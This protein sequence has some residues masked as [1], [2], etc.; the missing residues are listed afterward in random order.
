MVMSWVWVPVTVAVGLVVMQLVW[1]AS[2]S[3]RKIEYRR[4]VSWYLGWSELTASTS[5][6]SHGNYEHTA[7][8][9]IRSIR[10]WCAVAAVLVVASPAIWLPLHA[11][12]VAA[13]VGLFG[14]LYVGLAISGWRRNRLIDR[15]REVLKGSRLG[16]RSAGRNG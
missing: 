14:L 11:P 13:I 9:P 7:P 3:R 6:P 8:V 16:P 2:P 1:R 15:Y 10:L 5:I 4:G 12:V